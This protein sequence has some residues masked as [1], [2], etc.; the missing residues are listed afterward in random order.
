MHIICEK[1]LT[2]EMKALGYQLE[3]MWIKAAGE[4]WQVDHKLI[5]VK[6]YMF[7]K[8]KDSC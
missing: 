7:A 3:M 2:Q 8:E 6:S 4:V 5:K 1:E